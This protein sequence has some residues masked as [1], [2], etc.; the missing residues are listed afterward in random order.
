MSLDLTYLKGAGVYSKTDTRDNPA[1]V[2][3][4]EC[5]DPHEPGA[6]AVRPWPHY[7][8]PNPG[9][10]KGVDLFASESQSHGPQIA[11]LPHGFLPDAE[12][13]EGD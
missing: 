12:A 6:P 7:C 9:I 2:T 4:Q 13:K 1:V 10:G 5:P 3:C 11:R 8:Q